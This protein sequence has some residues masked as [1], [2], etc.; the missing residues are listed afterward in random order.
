MQP[1]FRPRQFSRYIGYGLLFLV[2]LLVVLVRFHLRTMPLERDEGEFA[3]AG[4]L[5][6]Q[7]IPPYVLAYSMKLPGTDATYAA[8]LAV[9]GQTAAGI[10]LGLILAN[11]AS[12][13][14]IFLLG[15]RLFGDL[16]GT[17]A[18]IS[19]A[20]LS[21]NTSVLGLAAHS[22]HFVV[23][24]VLAGT[25][26]LLRGLDSDND[27]LLFL[28]GLQFGL[29]FL[30]KQPGLAFTL[31][32]LVYLLRH[33]LRRPVN[34]RDLA[35]SAAALG[36]GAA[37]PFAF[38]C[39]WLWRSGE[40]PRFWFWTFSYASQ[41]ASQV[42]LRGVP[43]ILRIQLLVSVIP[44]IPIWLIAAAGAAAIPWDRR[45]RAH[46]F[47]ISAFSLFSLIA[48]CPGFYFRQHYF[49][50][51]LPSVSLLAG[52]AVSSA[53]C[54]L[55]ARRGSLAVGSVP[56][57]VF[58]AACS[59]V[60]FQQR[61]VLFQLDPRAACRSIYPPA[62]FNAAEEVAAHIARQTKPS[63]TVAVLGSEPEI[64]FYSRRHSATGY[65]YTYELTERQ[66]YAL[67]MQHEMIAE[68]ERARPEVLVLVNIPNSWVAGPPGPTDYIFDWL[69]EY[70]Q[71]KYVLDGIAELGQPSRYLWGD[72][73]RTYQQIVAGGSS[74]FQL[75]CIYV[76]K[77][78]DHAPR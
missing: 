36:L 2:T 7:G 53:A 14:L 69:D 25:L 34:L 1:E 35:A 31:F 19:Y 29:A 73:A 64:Y 5:M 18:A 51:L 50:L 41:Y 11:V 44:V 75:N 49:I 9:F 43:R 45:A 65:I 40:F 70:V 55:L 30:M 23:L 77:R 33:K 74:G 72:E 60:L 24:F 67:T 63:Q 17:V 8:I 28:S 48:L 26:L 42:S 54:W 6:L 16:A 32:A 47:F 71:K 15:R 61:Q 12:I 20:V 38:T 58:L 66:K 4:Q 78:N 21:I 52:I 37:L 22:T 76:F 13:L 3:Y 39:L 59:Y 68:I 56:V 27:W 46:A 62:P 57:L 10:H